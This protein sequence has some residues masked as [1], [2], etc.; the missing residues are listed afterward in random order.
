ML[1]KNKAKKYLLFEAL[2]NTVALFFIELSAFFEKVKFWT[3]VYKEKFMIF[4]KSILW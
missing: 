1:Q 2:F 3:R 4:S